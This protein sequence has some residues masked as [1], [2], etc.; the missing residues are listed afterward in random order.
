LNGRNDVLRL[1]DTADRE[2][3]IS[4]AAALTNLAALLFDVARRLPDRPA[5]SD[6]HSSRTYKAVPAGWIRR[7]VDARFALQ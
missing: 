4:A 1:A 6:D 7:I 3:R 2:T 5:V